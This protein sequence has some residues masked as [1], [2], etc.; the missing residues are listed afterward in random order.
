MPADQR[1]GRE[2]HRAAGG[3]DACRLSAHMRAQQIQ[4]AVQRRQ[5][6]LHARRG[7]VLVAFDARAQIT[8][9]LQRSRLKRCLFLHAEHAGHFA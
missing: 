3:L 1:R 6:P 4:V 8:E 2:G 7:T 9:L 5:L